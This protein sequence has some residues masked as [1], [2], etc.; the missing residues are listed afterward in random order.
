MNIIHITVKILIIWWDWITFRS[1]QWV[2]FMESSWIYSMFSPKMPLLYFAHFLK[3]A[4]LAQHLVWAYNVVRY[5][6]KYYT[7]CP[8]S[9]LWCVC[10]TLKHNVHS[11]CVLL[12]FWSLCEKLMMQCYSTKLSPLSLFLSVSCGF[13]PI[14][15]LVYKNMS[16]IIIIKT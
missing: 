16:A 10:L 1:S 5:Y 9:V 12:T 2:N 6:I 15:V 11:V 3:V 7:D 8:K 4:E 14:Y 13:K